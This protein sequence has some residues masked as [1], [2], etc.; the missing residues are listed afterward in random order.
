MRCI[1]FY[2]MA[3]EP[4]GQ[5]REILDGDSGYREGLSCTALISE[6][7]TALTT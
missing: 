2:G 5:R 6:A 3:E 4:S 1:L 7:A